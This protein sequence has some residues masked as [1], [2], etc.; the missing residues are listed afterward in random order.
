MALH[1]CVDKPS[2]EGGCYQELRQFCAVCCCWPS[3]NGFVQSLTFLLEIGHIASN[4]DE[5]ISKFRYVGFVANRPV[6]RNHHGR[7]H[8]EPEVLFGCADHCV[9]TAPGRVVNEGIDAIP[10]CVADVNNVRL[11]EENIDV[12]ICVSRTI[13][14]SLHMSI[15]VLH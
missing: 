11:L 7:L 9:D 5:H 10:P 15:A 13:V 4:G 12:A 6:P 8:H 14:P 3:R 2:E 1:T